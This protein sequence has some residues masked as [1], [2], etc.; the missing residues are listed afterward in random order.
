MNLSWNLADIA[1]MLDDVEL[2]DRYIKEIEE[3][4]S[5]N[6]KLSRLRTAFQKKVEQRSSPL[7]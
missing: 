7:S 3:V 2:A 4:D 5:S 1:L 6:E